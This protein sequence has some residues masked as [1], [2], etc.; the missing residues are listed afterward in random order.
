M[1]AVDASGREIFDRSFPFVPEPI[2]DGVIDSAIAARPTSQDAAVRARVDV[3]LREAAPAV[4]AEAEQVVIGSDD[5]IWI[6][7]RQTAKGTRWMVLSPTGDVV[8]E[9]L[10]PPR[11]SLRAADAEHVWCIE[12]DELDVESVVR[13]RLET[14]D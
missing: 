12:R 14:F 1:L 4:Y 5:R 3:K 10:L 11:V 7:M 13:Y 8:G 6:G 2:P 9:L